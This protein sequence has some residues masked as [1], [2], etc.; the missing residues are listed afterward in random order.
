MSRDERFAPQ[1][2]AVLTELR[3][4][5][6]ALPFAYAGMLK[7]ELAAL[8]E[9][10]DDAAFLLPASLCLLTAESLGAEPEEALPL[11]ASLAMLQLMAG[12]FAGIAA[13]TGG[14][15]LQRSWGL[16]R[17]VNAGDAFFALA[18]RA[19]LQNDSARARCTPILDATC[20]HLSKALFAAVTEGKPARA[21]P[22]R[23]QTPLL[24]AGVA[25]GTAVSRQWDADR[26]IEEA[27]SGGDGLAA[28]LQ[29]A[30]ADA[31]VTSRILDAFNSCVEVAGR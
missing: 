15:E 6:D 22:S 19:L 21:M 23:V 10:E 7:Q 5:L 29:A 18:N 11:A 16:P 20:R 28:Y 2:T 4:Q 24:A 12:V 17:T 3:R 26:G 9:E 1:R 30:G 25:L 14:G 13:S 27:L 31:A 8:S